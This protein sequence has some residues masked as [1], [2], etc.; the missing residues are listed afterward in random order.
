[1]KVEDAASVS[2]GESCEELLVA[3][4]NPAESTL[5]SWSTKPQE[6]EMVRIGSRLRV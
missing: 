2:L 6:G 3:S 4:I 5:D 1:M